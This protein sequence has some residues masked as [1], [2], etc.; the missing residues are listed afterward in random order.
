MNLTKEIWKSVKDYEKYY[1]VSNFGNVRSKHRI[2]KFGPR[3]REVG[4]DNLRKNDNGNSYLQVS[5]SVQ[6][7]HKNKYVHRLVAEAFIPNP[8]GLPEVNHIDGNKRNNTVNNLEWVTRVQNI[9]HAIS[10][11]LIAIGSRKSSAKLSRIEARQ[12]KREKLVGIPTKVIAKSHHC[13][14]GVVNDIA[15]G[16]RYAYDCN[17]IPRLEPK[18]RRQLESFYWKFMTRKRMNELDEE[19][20][21]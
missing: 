1:E 20:Q 3:L 15:I 16:A 2:V 8:L 21:K 4:K 10:H 14:V 19:M 12:I 11:K 7:K 17:D 9:D 18:K 13:S 6:G 5:F